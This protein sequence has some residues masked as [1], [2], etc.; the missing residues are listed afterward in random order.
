MRFLNQFLMG[1][2]LVISTEA[3]ASDSTLPTD[4]SAYQIKS[5][6]SVYRSGYRLRLVKDIVDQ[7]D[8]KGLVVI[9]GAP[10]SGKSEQMEAALPKNHVVFDLS[11]AFVSA[12]C[13][14]TGEDKKNLLDCYGGPFTPLQEILKQ[15][16]TVWLAKESESI[17]HELSDVAED[18][19]ILDEFDFMGSYKP[20]QS[21]EEAMVHMVKIGS[22]VKKAG[23][24][25]VFI[26]HGAAK[27]SDRFWSAMDQAFEYGVQDIAKTKFFTDDE[28]S[29]LLSQVQWT[30]TEKEI[31]LLFAEGSATAY[32]PILKK[33]TDLTFE[34]L[35]KQALNAAKAIVKYT[36][37][38]NRPDVWETLIAV[39]QGKLSLD[40]IQDQSLIEGIFESG[41]VGQKNGRLVMP[42]FAKESLLSSL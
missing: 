1:M 20:T 8:N 4:M 23:K 25:I 42:G 12:Y 29:Y 34:T 7:L 16:Q 36:K 5:A 17:I 41:F 31:F 28:E 15:E 27:N 24:Q 19:V 22:E 39:A 32:L 40:D 35:K 11:D 26:I 6:D 2:A 33:K 14:K 10:S 38:I 30:D 18:V 9:F 21:E 13:E 37:H 3:T